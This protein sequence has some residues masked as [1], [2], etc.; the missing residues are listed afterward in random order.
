MTEDLTMT[1]TRERREAKAKRLQGWADARG[2]KAEAGFRVGEE[3]RGDTAFWTQPGRIPER[4]RVHRA[5]ERAAEHAQKASG[6]KAKAAGI[7][8]QLDRAI[9]S[10]DPDAIEAL[11]AR[12][13]DL[14][15]KRDFYKKFSAATRKG[16]TLAD[17]EALIGRELSDRTRGNYADLATQ[18]EGL[19]PWMLSNLSAD[20]RRN[21]KRLQ[22]LREQRTSG[23][24]VRV[25]HARRD[26]AC[27]TCG[28][29]ITAGEWIGR[30]SNGWLHVTNVEG[31]WA[32]A[33][34]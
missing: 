5:H 22:E 15:G 25:I 1:T 20:L 21:V 30:Y 11:T 12:I 28:G 26:G 6:M 33:C 29:A 34:A 14:E 8:S 23:R 24:P 17:F 32:P 18:R 9:Y 3:Y 31:S 4:D 13:A 7:L 2:E 19:P 10:D 27:E 16:T